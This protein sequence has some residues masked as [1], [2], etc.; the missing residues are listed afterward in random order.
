MLCRSLMA[1]CGKGRSPLTQA[2]GIF[3]LGE[4]GLCYLSGWNLIV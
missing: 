2:P 1:E 3:G 4:G